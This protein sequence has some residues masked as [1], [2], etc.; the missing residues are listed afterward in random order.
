MGRRPANADPAT[1]RG[2]CI[3]CLARPQ[4]PKTK[5]TFRPRCRPCHERRFPRKTRWVRPPGFARRAYQRHRG[6][7]CEKCGFI[8]EH[9]CQLDVDHIDGDHGN[10]SPDNLQTLCANCHRLK[11]HKSRDYVQKSRRRP[12]S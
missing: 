2:I 1:V 12:Y 7:A 3:D 8:A 9:P 11:S 4:S 5:T 10:D 6:S